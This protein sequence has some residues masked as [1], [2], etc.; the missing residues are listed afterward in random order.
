MKRIIG[1]AIVIFLT[2]CAGKSVDK[3]TELEKLKKDRA[4][5]NS[6]ISA[7]C[8]AKLYS[9]LAV[10]WIWKYRIERLNVVY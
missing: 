5:L 10:A 4:E 8:S 9:Y 7:L 1:I 2:S 6:K 3:V